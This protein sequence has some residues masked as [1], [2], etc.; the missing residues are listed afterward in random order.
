PI[1]IVNFEKIMGPNTSDLL[2]SLLVIF[3]EET[4]PLLAQIQT[5]VQ[6][7]NPEHLRQLAHSLWGS[8]ASVAAI[9]FSAL[10]YELEEIGKG[11]DISPALPILAQMETEF[12]RIEAWV[13]SR[14]VGEPA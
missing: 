14:M 13:S 11:V 1:N 5:A 4:P 6:D 10:S 8:S 7:N 12:A 2:S 3:L 9:P